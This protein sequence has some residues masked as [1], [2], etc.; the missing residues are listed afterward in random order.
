M[1]NTITRTFTTNFATC[2]AYED[3]KIITAEIAL[4]DSCGTPYTAEKYIRKNPSVLSGKLVQ[5]DSIRKE[6]VL[7][8][9][10]ETDFIKFATPVA[11]RSKDTRDKITKTVNAYKG[12]FLYMN[13]ASRAVESREISVPADMKNK[14]DKYMKVIERENEKAIM[15]ENLTPVAALYAISELDFKS[16]AKRMIDHQHYAE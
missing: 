12:T 11:A 2:L 13:T 5:V 4:P 14:L 6:T 8:G 10:D 1:R 16:H 9:M 3:G 7:Y 15:I